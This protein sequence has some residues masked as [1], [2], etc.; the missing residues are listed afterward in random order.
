MKTD[1]HNMDLEQLLATLEH[2][3]RDNRR[4]EEISAMIDNMAAVHNHGFWW[5]AA[6]VAAVA[7]VFFFISTAVRIWFIPTGQ[8]AGR[9]V[10]EA[11]VKGVV[12]PD[13]A[14]TT[15]EADPASTTKAEPAVKRRHRPRVKSVAVQPVAEEQPESLPSEE[16]LAEEKA[17]D[18]FFETV[19]EDEPFDN[20]IA[21]IV[22]PLVSVSQANEPAPVEPAPAKVVT[23]A[24]RSLLGTL[25]HRAEPSKMD[26]TMLAINIL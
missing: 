25:F 3:G 5:Y 26:G 15:V 24:R 18:E 6:R 21:V 23:P 7:C 9:Q 22:Q 13:I 11:V 12:S 16:F 19:Q 20:Q 1:K 17:E 10:A 4:Q 14:A 2:A 8:P